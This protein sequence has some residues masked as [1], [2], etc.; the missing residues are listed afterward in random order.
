MEKP[1]KFLK[2]VQKRFHKRSQG[3]ITSLNTNTSPNNST[4]E[5][6]VKNETS[7]FEDPSSAA[8]VEKENTN[9]EYTNGA[10][11]STP[12]SQNITSFEDHSGVAS[13]VPSSQR[14]DLT[15][16]DVAAIKIQAI[17][18]GHQVCYPTHYIFF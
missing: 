9:S 8:I 18:R 7:N 6:I 15:K 5:A 17:F 13:L 4:E 14:K 2:I 10:I 16:E 11:P 1:E 3:D 12:T